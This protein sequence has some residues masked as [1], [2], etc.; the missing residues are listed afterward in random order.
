MTRSPFLKLPLFLLILFWLLGQTGRVLAQEPAAQPTEPTPL[1]LTTSASTQTQPAV[2]PQ[3][4]PPPNRLQVVF[5]DDGTPF[6]FMTP[7]G[8]PSGFL[9]EFWRL[10]GQKAGLEVTFLPLSADKAIPYVLGNPGYFH[11][12]T[13]SDTQRA[14]QLDFG[15]PVWAT[16]VHCFFHESLPGVTSLADLKPYRVGVIEADQ[17]DTALRDPLAGL[18]LVPYPNRA[19]LYEAV[20]KGEIRV[21]VDNTPTALRLL[22]QKGVL[23]QFR[24]QV[25][26]PLITRILRPALAKNQPD[27]IARFNAAVG[28]IST[29]ER[30]QL[31]GRWM[32]TA[33]TSASASLTLL[34]DRDLAPYSLLDSSSRPIGLS[35]AFWTLWGTTNNRTVAFRAATSPANA[36][37]RLKGN[38]ADLYFGPV[39]LGGN[40]PARIV[41]GKDLFFAPCH[42][43]CPA[44]KPLSTEPQALA[45]Q[46]IAVLRDDACDR[47]LQQ[48]APTAQRVPFD[49]IEEAVSATREGKTRAFAT[50][51]AVAEN[52]LAR[53]GLASEFERS[54]TE[55]CSA[56]LHLAALPERNDLITETERGLQPVPT[57]KLL[58]MESRWIADAELRYW[59]DMPTSL[60]LTPKETIWLQA[61]GT[62]RLGVNAGHA[63]FENLSGEDELQGIGGAMVHL[64]EERTGLRLKVAPLP[65][66]NPAELANQIQTRIVQHRLD[67]ALCIPGEKTLPAELKA[68]DPYA[69]LPLVFVTRLDSPVLSGIKALAGKNVALAQVD[70]LPDKLSAIEKNLKITLYKDAREAVE[71]VAGGQADIFV[72]DRATAG[73]TV[74]KV[75]G[76]NLKIAGETREVEQTM[77]FGVRADWPELLTLLNKTIASM[78]DTE[79]EEAFSQWVDLR[80]DVRS[81]EGGPPLYWLIGV[82]VLCGLLLLLLLNALFRLRRVRVKTVLYQRIL[83]QSADTTLILSKDG[84]CRAVSQ[85]VRLHLGRSSSE[86]QGQR[87]QIFAEDESAQET[88]RKAIQEAVEHPERTVRFECGF[89][90]KEG[91]PTNLEGLL[92]NRFKDRTLRGLLLT[93]RNTVGRRQSEIAARKTES[94]HQLLFDQNFDAIFLLDLDG[95]VVNLNHRA[96]ELFQISRSKALGRSLQ[97]D[98]SAPDAP[99]EELKKA[100]R[101]VAETGYALLEWLALRPSDG[102]VIPVEMALRKIQVG[103]SDLVVASLRDRSG[104]QT[105][106]VAKRENRPSHPVPPKPTPFRFR[107]PGQRGV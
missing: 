68:T 63:P 37:E 59:R 98:F 41:I 73:Y 99:L 23:N 18:A 83:D 61:H 7:D 96:T 13:W 76:A 95:K 54:D 19:A 20:A 87:L 60:T 34:L 58:Q 14:T 48:H 45:N 55:L 39:R 11:A 103:E 93:L 12:G 29:E 105:D 44:G 33:Q 43:F 51:S 38:E 75:G 21:F 35:A 32:N 94:L 107:L 72:T 84:V 97:E 6:Q 28:K 90:H 104:H 42:L 101:Q 71:A 78:T 8:K 86:L 53:T 91:L 49:R 82:A 22:A 4:T 102:E 9:V 56:G 64:V 36:L 16:P 57:A 2:P 77:A 106:S 69:R 15:E 30:S 1:P 5:E 62:V 3:P 52:H 92:I 65:E 17:T 47:W 89:K 25:D 85:A 67:V 66:A 10:A 46:P 81:T 79:R 70:N 100:G 40:D 80:F 88:L 26:H 27:L 50:L 31:V 24:H 74:S